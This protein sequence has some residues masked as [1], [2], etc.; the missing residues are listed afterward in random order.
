[1]LIISRF[2]DYYDTASVYGIDKTCVYQRKADDVPLER[3]HWNVDYVLKLPNGVPFPISRIYNRS[4]N[5][6]RGNTIGEVE[7]NQLVIGF[8]GQFY[9]VAIFSP[10]FG[11]G[12]S[13]HFYNAEDLRVFIEKENVFNN[14]SRYRYFSPRWDKHNLEYDQGISSFFDVSSM[15]KYGELFHAFRI[16][17]FSMG[18]HQYL[19]LNPCLKDLGFMKVKDPQTAFQDIY[20]FLMGVIGSPP[21]KKEKIDD[22]VM[23]ASKGHDDEYSFKKQPGKRGRNRWR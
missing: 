9:P 21:P 10:R 13:Y 17:I 23:A 14:R 2:H 16:P 5:I 18:N 19:T 11:D 3:A 20:S 12:K 1:M 6:Y 4:G 8:C 22:K 7:L 15:G